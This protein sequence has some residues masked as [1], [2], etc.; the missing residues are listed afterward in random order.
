MAETAAVREGGPPP[1]QFQV[2]C[3]V[4]RPLLA[5]ESGIP[6]GQS[7]LIPAFYKMIS[8]RFPRTRHGARRRSCGE[9]V[10]PGS[11]RMEVWMTGA[12]A[13]SLLFLHDTDVLFQAS[14]SHP[15]RRC[16][17]HADISDVNRG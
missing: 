4:L 8:G 1:R 15:L 13:R 3:E 5:C 14:A 11:Y 12:A 7:P 16:R 17:W 2:E 10:E 6:R 9:G